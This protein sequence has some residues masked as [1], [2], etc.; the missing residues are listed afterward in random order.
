MMEKY[1]TQISLRAQKD[2]REIAAYITHELQQSESALNV[3]NS[4]AEVIASLE[5]MP[6]RFALVADTRL[7]RR[8]IR[9]LKVGSYL[10]F[11]IIDKQS[12]IVH[13]LGVLYERRDWQHIL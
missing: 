4:L 13:I 12:Q 9:K 2:M 10:V 7:A 5:K 1:E 8:G 6:E 11:F 3:V